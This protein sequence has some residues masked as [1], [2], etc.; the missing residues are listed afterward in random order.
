[1]V[2]AFLFIVRESGCHLS[3][4]DLVWKVSFKETEGQSLSLLIPNQKGGRKLEM[5][6]WRVIAWRVIARYLKKLEEFRL[7][8][9]LWVYNKTS[10]KMNRTR[11]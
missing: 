2:L 4:E 5:L 10:K 8:S 7:Q 1:M 6:V 9:S 11:I 3:E